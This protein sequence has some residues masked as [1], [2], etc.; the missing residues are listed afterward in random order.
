M[1]S[2]DRYRL[3]AAQGETL[4]VAG[5]DLTRQYLQ[6]MAGDLTAA[7][8]VEFVVKNGN[9][10]TP[11]QILA[12]F[13]TPQALAARR[14]ALEAHQRQCAISPVACGSGAGHVH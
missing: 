14:E 4:L 6:F 1:V 2:I 11:A 5:N 13:R 12:P 10:I 9:V 3:A 8:N 7:A